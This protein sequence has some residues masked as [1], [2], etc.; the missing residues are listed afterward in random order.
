[1]FLT[2]LT[3]LDRWITPKPKLNSDGFV[4]SR[5]PPL[6][7]IPATGSSPAQAPREGQLSD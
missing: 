1:M 5:I 4:K 6:I 2:S 7:W 3:E